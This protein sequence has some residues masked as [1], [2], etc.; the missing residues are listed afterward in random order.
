MRLI[1]NAHC[2]QLHSHQTARL[3]HSLFIF[4]VWTE[5]H[6]VL[7]TKSPY[8]STFEWPSSVSPVSLGETVKAASNS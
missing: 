3:G 6:I 4:K 1:L 8:M 7:V 2:V 5:A